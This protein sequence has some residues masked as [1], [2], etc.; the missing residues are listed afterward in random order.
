MYQGHHR[1]KKFSTGNV[2]NDVVVTAVAHV[3]H[4]YCGEHFLMYVIVEAPCCS[5]ET[6]VT[7]YINF[8]STQ[9]KR[10]TRGGEW[11]GVQEKVKLSS[12]RLTN[13]ITCMCYDTLPQEPPTSHLIY[14][15]DDPLH[16]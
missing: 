7:V 12:P 16:R 5:P 1:D 15:Y 3:G 6:N 14:P 13:S 10:H 8:T 11:E 4:T 9:E 2:A